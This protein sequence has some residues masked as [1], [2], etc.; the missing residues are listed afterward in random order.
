M[1]SANRSLPELPHL[2]FPVS[3]QHAGAVAGVLMGSLPAAKN[4]CGWIAVCNALWLCGV[5]F[6]PREVVRSFSRRL[7][8]GGRLGAMPWQITRALRLFGKTAFKSPRVEKTLAGMSR[9]EAAILLVK[10]RGSSVWHYFAV[11][12]GGEG[13]FEA[14]NARPARGDAKALQKNYKFIFIWKIKQ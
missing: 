2:T 8:F 12:A 3:D 10:N 5:G 7:L 11:R 4:G 13:L 14:F 9:G 6:D 1:R